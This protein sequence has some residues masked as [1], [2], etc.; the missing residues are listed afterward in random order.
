MNLIPQVR[1][2]D[3]KD[4]MFCAESAQGIYIMNNNFELSQT[5]ELLK[6]RFCEYTGFDLQ[7]KIVSGDDLPG[8]YLD[9]TDIGEEQY[10][11]SITLRRIVLKGNV[12]GGLFL[13]VQ[14]LSQIIKLSGLNLPCLEITDYPEM[15]HRGF[16]HDVT[17]GK[18]PKLVTLK[19]L[20]EKLAYYK[21][22]ELQ[23]YVEH[24]FAFKSFPELWCGKDPLTAEEIIDL[25]NYCK[26][27]HID[28]IPSLA[29]FGHLYELLRLKRFEHLNE[30][31]IQASQQSH[32]LWDRMAHYTIDPLND[33][34][35]GVIK[36]MIGEYL[37]LFSS[38]YFNICC[39]ETFDL[40]KGKNEKSAK[41]KGVGRLYVDF[42]KKIAGFVLEQG[43]IPMMW[44]DIVLHHPELIGE[45]PVE[46]VFLN[47]GYTADVSEENTKSFFQNGVTQYVCPGIQGW[48]RV[49]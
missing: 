5:A 39:D 40:G 27:F 30:L 47:W 36:L 45:L 3:Y 42:V 6:V 14:T 46:T 15:K 8:I 32:N 16:Y 35:F 17:R 34:S 37:P 19:L 22:N 21:L 28:L 7:V 1:S 33:E 2:C 26:K 24:S 23:L 12:T 29:T 11:V 4:G 13:A 49:G 25:D 18:V 10:Q 38:R 9:G 41:E 31:D 43:K 20:V 44:G 48:S